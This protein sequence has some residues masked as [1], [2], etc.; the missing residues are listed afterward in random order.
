MK[1]KERITVH[2]IRNRNKCRNR[3]YRERK[4]N[5]KKNEIHERKLLLEIFKKKKNSRKTSNIKRIK[6][7]MKEI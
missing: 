5:K 4:G 3:N 2:G 6:K 7:E 1:R